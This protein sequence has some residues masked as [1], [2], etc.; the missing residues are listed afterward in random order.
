MIK[1]IICIDSS[2][3]FFPA[4]FNYERMILNN[5][6][7]GQDNFVMAP[8]YVYFTSLLS[9]LKKIHVDVETKVLI[10]LEGHSWRKLID[11][12]YKSQR[13]GD[14]EK[15]VL[16]NWDKEFNSL[17]KLHEQLNEST[18]FYFLRH[19]E[20]ESDD[21]C[22][23]VPK[24]FPEIECI[25]VTGDHDLYQLA[26]YNNVKIF[27]VN[28]KCHG[29]KGIYETDIKNPLKIISDKVR[30]GD[31]SDNILVSID[32]EPEDFALRYK[33]VN[34]LQL[35]KD[36]EQKGID[37]I[38]DALS[39]KKENKLD[40]LPN[41]KNVREKFMAIYDEKTKITYEYCESLN[42]KRAK[43]KAQIVKEKRQL[44]KEKENAGV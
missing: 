23:I 30:L 38:R 6:A 40:L 13:A 32:D 9:C 35:P 7:S 17:N 37:T 16:I 42:A 8:Y 10:T 22:A 43:K 41:F 44:K 21:L 1:K 18:E 5:Q 20:L 2:T 26:W 15:H 25:I 12:N 3:L 36:I 27:N 14:R 33:L 31:K 28:K 4:V 29:S 19:P 24:I 34:L 39:I 11:S